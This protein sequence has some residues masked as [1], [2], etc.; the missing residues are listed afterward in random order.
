MAKSSKCSTFDDTQSRLERISMFP[1]VE[2]RV[3]RENR[4]ALL[5]RK[6]CPH[7]ARSI[8]VN[9]DGTQR[10]HFC[11]HYTPCEAGRCVLCENRPA[12]A[13]VDFAKENPQTDI[14]R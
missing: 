11:P 1:L 4:R 12:A 2:E 8:T 13:A 14:E 9:R 10:S 5:P 3:A 6:H 7:C